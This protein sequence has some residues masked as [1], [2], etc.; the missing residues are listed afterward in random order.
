MSSVQTQAISHC[1]YERMVIPITPIKHSPY[2]SRRHYFNNNIVETGLFTSLRITCIV[3]INHPHHPYP[4]DYS[5]LEKLDTILD[6]GVLTLQFAN[7][8]NELD[9]VESM[10]WIEQ[11]LGMIMNHNCGLQLEQSS[12]SSTPTQL[13]NPT[14]RFRPICNTTSPINTPLAIALGRPAPHENLIKIYLRLEW[15]TEKLLSLTDM[16][17]NPSEDMKEY[18]FNTMLHI[19]CDHMGTKY[20]LIFSPIYSKKLVD[21]TRYVPVIAKSIQR[22]IETEKND[23]ETNRDTMNMIKTYLND[24]TILRRVYN[25]SENINDNDIW[26]DLV[27]GLYYYF[28]RT[29]PFPKYPKMTYTSIQNHQQ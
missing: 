8:M 27:I 20:P 29:L 16:L 21:M 19:F 26:T 14:Y 25:Y 22:M 10:T 1:H 17:E 23:S 13:H 24:T 4:N 7:R 15:Q 2:G 18:L 5:S 11:P 28:K 6:Q 12:V 3:Q 9:C